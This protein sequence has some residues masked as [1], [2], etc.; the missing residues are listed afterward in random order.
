MKRSLWPA[1]LGLAA[2][3]LLALIVA[4]VAADGPSGAEQTKLT[5]ADATAS[6]RFGGSV[7]ISGDTV[8]VGAPRDDTSGSAYVFDRVLADITVTL[9][10]PGEPDADDLRWAFKHL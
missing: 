10:E 5:D 9:A 7:A 4:S 1:G 2:A 3:T 6:D 8:I